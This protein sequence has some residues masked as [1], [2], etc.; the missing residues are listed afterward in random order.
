MVNEAEANNMVR[1][2]EKK[3]AIIVGLNREIRELKREV[4]TY[5]SELDIAA[6]EIRRL[7][8]S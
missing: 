8:R 6:A 4:D 2:I 7:E 3:N 1:E 5:K